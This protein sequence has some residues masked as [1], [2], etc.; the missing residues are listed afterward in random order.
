MSRADDVLRR[1]I[2]STAARLIADGGLDYA[3]AKMRAAQ[4]AF[5]RRAPRHA[6]PNN[7]EVDAA[8]R[9]HLA[10]FDEH[11]DERVSR[12]RRVALELMERLEEFRPLA[13]GA[14]WKGVAAEHA[15]IHLQLFAD[16]AKE[17]EYW[18]LNRN[19]DFDV[20]TIEHFRGRR[21]V[22]ALALYWEGEPVLLSLYDADDLR[23]ALQAP[24]GD[25]A[26][27]GDRHALAARAALAR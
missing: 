4:A 21:E 20:A 7:D 3:S 22:P 18:L 16:N 24:R 14:V 11:H 27:R 17:V 10:L 9:E 5:G 1:E 15:P 8:L 26:L 25:D 13:T 2:A 23:G 19:V 12:L 6:I